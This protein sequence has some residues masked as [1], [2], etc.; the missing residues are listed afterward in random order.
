MERERVGGDGG[1]AMRE[2]EVEEKGWGVGGGC[3]GH[4]DHGVLMGQVGMYL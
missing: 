3:G 1:C 4:V 2:E